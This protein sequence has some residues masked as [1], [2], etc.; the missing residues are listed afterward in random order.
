MKKSILNL[1]KILNK[2]EQKNITGSFDNDEYGVCRSRYSFSC[3]VPGHICC[4]YLCV[5]PEHPACGLGL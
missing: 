4:N 2:D 1:G 3:G 5:L